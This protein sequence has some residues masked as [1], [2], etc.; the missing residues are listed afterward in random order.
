MSG[1]WQAENNSSEL[2]SQLYTN[3]AAIA[4]VRPGLVQ[5]AYVQVL[6]TY[7]FYPKCTSGW[8][9]NY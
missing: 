5:E 3:A 7:Y 2:V 9:Y 4:A 6:L 8:A 1:Q